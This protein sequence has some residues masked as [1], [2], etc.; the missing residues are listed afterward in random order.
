VAVT[1]KAAFDEIVLASHL[2][3]DISQKL[4]RIRLSLFAAG[5]SSYLGEPP[6]LRWKELD[7]K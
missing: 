3:L 4:L 1:S 7:V 2:L 5:L 6:R